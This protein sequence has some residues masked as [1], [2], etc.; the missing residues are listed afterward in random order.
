MRDLGQC[1]EVKREPDH[2]GK[3]VD[4]ER[5][6]KE[7]IKIVTGQTLKKLRAPVFFNK[8]KKNRSSMPYDMN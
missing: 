5:N 8:K 1:S 4:V 2:R 7:L 3:I 6:N